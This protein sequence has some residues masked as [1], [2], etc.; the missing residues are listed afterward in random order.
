MHG[1]MQDSDNGAPLSRTQDKLDMTISSLR[2]RDI[3]QPTGT[4]LDA[5]EPYN[6]DLDD[7]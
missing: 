7:L 4:R 5:P 2:S 1:S 6:N 3:L